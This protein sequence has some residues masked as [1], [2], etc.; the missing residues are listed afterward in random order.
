[1]DIPLLLFCL[2]DFAFLSILG[3]DSLISY[4]NY[5]ILLILV[6]AGFFT[7]PPL[8]FYAR[9]YSSPSHPKDR[10][11]YAKHSY[12][13][14]LYCISRFFLLFCYVIVVTVDTANLDLPFIFKHFPADAAG[15]SITLLV[16][17]CLLLLLHYLKL[18]PQFNHRYDLALEAVTIYETKYQGNGNMMQLQHNTLKAAQ[19]SSA[20]QVYLTPGNAL[21]R[22][23]RLP[24]L[25]T[26]AANSG[27]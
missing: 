15:V 21:H 27:V 3:I 20:A 19:L 24:A 11:W 5:P 8:W 6:V 10:F 18:S 2:L 9:E 22:D 13:G 1:M 17:L 12:Y 7:Y 4:N 26:N 16:L 23:P 14:I 25:I